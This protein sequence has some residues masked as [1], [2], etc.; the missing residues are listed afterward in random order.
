MTV[1]ELSFVVLA[2]NVLSEKL[3]L[4]ATDKLLD[5]PLSESV[6]KRLALVGIT[7]VA[8]VTK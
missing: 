8:E 2:Q 7:T 5:Q 6:Q 3:I 1:E 4:Q